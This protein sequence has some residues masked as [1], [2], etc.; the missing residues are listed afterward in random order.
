M[1]NKTMK[2]TIPGYFALAWF[3]TGLTYFAGSRLRLDPASLHQTPRACLDPISEPFVVS[4]E[5][6]PDTGWPEAWP[7][8]AVSNDGRQLVVGYT[9]LGKYSD[10][11]AVVARRFD[12][13]G[14]PLGDE[15]LVD[16]EGNTEDPSIDFDDY[17][18][19]TIA[20]HSSGKTGEKDLDG[21]YSIYLRAY[22]SEGKTLSD[23]VLVPQDLEGNQWRPTNLVLADGTSLITWYSETGPDQGSTIRGRLFKAGKAIS[24]EFHISTAQDRPYNQWRMGYASKNKFFISVWWDDGAEIGYLENILQEPETIQRLLDPDSVYLARVIDYEGNF[25]SYVLGFPRATDFVIDDSG[26]WIGNS[27]GIAQWH[28]SDGNSIGWP[29]PLHQGE[30]AMSGSGDF[31]VY[32]SEGCIWPYTA[33]GNLVSDPISMGRTGPWAGVDGNDH[34]DVV[35][36]WDTTFHDGPSPEWDVW[37]SISSISHLAGHASSAPKDIA[38]ININKTIPYT[39]I[40]SLLMLLASVYLLR[41]T[42]DDEAL[43]LIAMGLTLNIVSSY[44]LWL[45]AGPI[46][47]GIIGRLA[48]YHQ[49]AALF[50]LF[51]ALATRL[52]RPSS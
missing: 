30:F 46:L 21:G 43:P 11:W 23:T 13:S 51:V 41:R 26:N 28:I 37:V 44:V 17:G 39:A 47:G 42:K 8:V 1:T 20:W 6:G 24:D 32:G 48:R 25:R 2:L 49:T 34:G 16:A 18:N 33:S 31:I 36:T 4:D 9:V 12:L 52:S 38:L 14:T 40:F 27:G 5:S 10:G 45:Y 15:F 3:I 7:E 29:F 22:S 19:F 35:A 50:S